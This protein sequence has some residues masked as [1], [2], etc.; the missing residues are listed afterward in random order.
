MPTSVVCQ[1][2]LCA[3]L[4][5]IKNGAARFKPINGTP[6]YI[7]KPNEASVAIIALRLPRNPSQG[8]ER[9]ASN[10]MH[11]ITLKFSTG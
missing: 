10:I 9:T 1:R 6:A 11:V 8:F 3:Y 7:A 4:P 5:I 2:I